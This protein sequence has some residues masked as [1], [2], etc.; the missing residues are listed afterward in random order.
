MES[1]RIQ[2][3][4]LKQPVWVNSKSKLLSEKEFSRRWLLQGNPG[5]YCLKRCAVGWEVPLGRTWCRTDQRSLTSFPVLLLLSG[6]SFSGIWSC[7]LIAQEVQDSQL[8]WLFQGDKGGRTTVKAQVI[9]FNGVFCLVFHSLFWKWPCQLIFHLLLFLQT[10]MRITKM[11]TE[12]IRKEELSIFLIHLYLLG[13]IWWAF[14]SLRR[15][16]KPMEVVFSSEL[17]LL[18]LGLVLFLSYLLV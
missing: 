8:W 6:K 18:C 12:Y 10:F 5:C 9:V 3:T 4:L 7:H 14:W 13:R 17:L 2:V 1:H 15:L 16:Q 11:L